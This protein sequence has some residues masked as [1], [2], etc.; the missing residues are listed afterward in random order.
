MNCVRMVEV[1]QSKQSV[2]K[3]T[4]YLASKPNTQNKKLQV[5]CRKCVIS[6]QEACLHYE[7]I[8]KQEVIGE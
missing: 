1:V 2:L 4:H 3:C 5:F 7:V 8:I 6:L